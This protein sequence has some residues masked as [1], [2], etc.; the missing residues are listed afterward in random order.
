MHNDDTRIPTAPPA[1][2]D[3]GTIDALLLEA[4]AREMLRHTDLAALRL[5]WLRYGLAA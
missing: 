5:E 2:H 4:G 3:D 1:D